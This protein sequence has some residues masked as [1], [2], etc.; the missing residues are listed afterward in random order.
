MSK[1]KHPITK[2]IKR[3]K[4]SEA[5]KR[6][7]ANKGVPEDA[8]NKGVEFFYEFAEVF[9]EMYPEG[10]FDVTHVMNWATSYTELDHSIALPQM[11]ANSYA[12]GRFL[13]HNQEKLGIEYTGSYGNR[14]MYR[15]IEEN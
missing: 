13:M 5:L 1:V 9:Q 14:A 10:K 7:S 3:A 4:A 8:K 2:N 11:F 15:V 6:S 12:L